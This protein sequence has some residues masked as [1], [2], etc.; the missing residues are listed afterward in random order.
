MAAWIPRVGST[1][2]LGSVFAC[3]NCIPGDA[4]RWGT[5]LVALVGGFLLASAG[6]IGIVWT[7]GWTGRRA[8]SGAAL[9]LALVASVGARWPV[10]AESAWCGSAVSASRLRG[11]PSDR[12]LDRVQQACKSAG[13]TRLH[14]SQGL[15]LAA[16]LCAIAVLG[17]FLLSASGVDRSD[18]GPRPTPSDA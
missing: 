9:L 6:W 8:A 13:E 12:A 14:Q 4:G 5:V 2:N 10:T 15:A 11:W 1:R 18:T 7:W 16:V 3:D 17:H